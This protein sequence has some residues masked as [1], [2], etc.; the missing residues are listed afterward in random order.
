VHAAWSFS[1]GLTL[2]LNGDYLP[3]TAFDLNGAVGLRVFF[4]AMRGEGQKA[5]N[6]DQDRDG[7]PG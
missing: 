6:H 1:E 7:R 2:Q 3:D 5:P 4:G